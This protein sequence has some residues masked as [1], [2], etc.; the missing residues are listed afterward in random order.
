MESFVR[1]EEFRPLIKA[2]LPWTTRRCVRTSRTGPNARR[3]C[4][5]G[6]G[7]QKSLGYALVSIFMLPLLGVAKG[8]RPP[9]CP[10]SREGSELLSRLE[11]HVQVD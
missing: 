9:S 6:P 7:V 10:P 8:G 11:Q 4:N 2:L 1:S 5:A 3:V